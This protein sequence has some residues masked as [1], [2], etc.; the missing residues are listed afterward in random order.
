MYPTVSKFVIKRLIQLATAWLGEAGFSAMFVLKTKH[1]NRLEVE[2]DLRL[3]LRKVSP[4]F[5]KLTTAGK[6]SFLISVIV[7]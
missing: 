3:C 5:Q 1:Q 2:A 6:H 7:E 4:R